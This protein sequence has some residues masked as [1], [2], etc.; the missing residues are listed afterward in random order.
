MLKVKVPYE[1][2]KPHVASELHCHDHPE[3]S[4]IV[5]L[6]ESKATEEKETHEKPSPIESTDSVTHEEVFKAQSKDSSG[7]T[8]EQ[9]QNDVVYCGEKKRMKRPI[10][11][12]PVTPALLHKNIDKLLPVIESGEWLTDE[13]I[14]N[15]QAILA[16]NFPY[17]GGLQATWVF[18]SEECQSLGTP[19]EDFVQI[20]NVAGNH[21][22]TLSNIGCPKDTVMLY[23]S[24]YNDL[25]P[26]SKEK[27]KKQIAYMLMPTSEHV[28]IQWADVQKQTGTSDCG[29][30]AIA[31][32]TSLCYG[33]SPQDCNW[34]QEKMRDHL[35]KCFQQ[36]D[37]A[38]FPQLPIVRKHKKYIRVEKT[39]VFCHCR[40]PYKPGVVMIACDL[41]QDWFHRGCERVPKRVN[42]NTSF[43]CKNCK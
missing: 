39:K 23:D 40:Q 34:E 1:Q 35:C 16:A 14:D 31:A 8:K 33:I 4:P 20:V 19:K 28:T 30:F 27:L 36:K 7:S 15:A 3:L 11:P 21:W 2:I 6:E 32:A 13:H 10:G 37:M 18:I 24:L 29:L 25:D 43:I 17:I 22:V 26:I 5:S 12:L 42:K 9:N 41:C 38:L